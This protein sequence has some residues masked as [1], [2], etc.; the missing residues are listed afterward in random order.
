MVLI[1]M[2]CDM[3]DMKN[4]CLLDF[5]DIRNIRNTNQPVPAL[6]LAPLIQPVMGPISHGSLI[7]ARIV[8][9][10]GKQDARSSFFMLV[11]LHC[12]AI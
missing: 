12:N 2:D 3:T 5:L 9:S 8:L 11:V 7:P 1:P 6:P 4:L 10:P